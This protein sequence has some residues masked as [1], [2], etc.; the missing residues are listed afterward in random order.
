MLSWCCRWLIAGVSSSRCGSDWKICRMFEQR[1]IKSH[2]CNST[3]L[4]YPYTYD[5][6]FQQ[7]WNGI[8][9]IYDVA[10]GWLVFL[11]V[12]GS[13]WKIFEKCLINYQPNFCNTAL[14]PYSYTYDNHSV[15][16][17]NGISCFLDVAMVDSCFLPF[18]DLID[19]C[20]SRLWIW[21]KRSRKG[22]R[23]TTLHPIHT[24]IISVWRALKLLS[25]IKFDSN[26]VLR[27]QKYSTT[28]RKIVPLVVSL[29]LNF[30]HHKLF[31]TMFVL[32]I[33]SS[34]VKK[35]T[36]FYWCRKESDAG[37][38]SAFA[39]ASFVVRMRFFFF[40]TR[41]VVS[42]KRQ[43]NS[44][45]SVLFLL[46]FSETPDSEARISWYKLFVDFYI[47]SVLHHAID[48]SDTNRTS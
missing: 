3:M 21:L 16:C 44:T 13:D 33:L 11:Q 34:Y 28:T 35:T 45:K 46:E 41:Y 29:F 20:L 36:K 5:K 14:C 40:A 31:F 19:C 47:Q 1:S 8:L 6:P 42:A 4:S 2:S 7:C 23:G 39:I 43:Y 22:C 24:H 9:S 37:F 30:P 26:R 25:L 48:G 38:V 15:Q 12:C 32:G 27:V 18:V 10:S 17:L